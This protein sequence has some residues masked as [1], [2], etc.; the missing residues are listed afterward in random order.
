MADETNLFMEK[1]RNSFSNAKNDIARLENSLL[2]LKTSVESNKEDIFGFPF[3]K[4]A[5]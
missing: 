4:K 2:N 1:V 3:S 5:F